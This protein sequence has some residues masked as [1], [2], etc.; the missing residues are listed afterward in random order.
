MSE[1]GFYAPGTESDPHA[2]WNQ[3]EPVE[4]PRCGG[5]GRELY[6]YD[7][8]PPEDAEDCTQCEGEGV[9]DPSE[10]EDE[11][12]YDAERDRQ[13]ERANDVGEEL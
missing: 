12:D 2:P 7:G 4:C 3:P 8:E 10:I 5:T 11:P 6:T 1:S 13:D 9:V